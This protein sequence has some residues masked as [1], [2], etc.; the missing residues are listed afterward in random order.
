MNMTSTGILFLV[1]TVIYISAGNAKNVFVNVFCK[2]ENVGQFGQQS[3]LEC[4][5][6]TI[7]EAAD[8]KIRVVTWKKQGAKKPLLVFHRAETIQQP[9]YEFAEPSWNDKNM[10]VS[11]LINKTL[12]SDAG[13]YMCTVMTNSGDGESHANLKVTAKYSVPVIRSIPEKIT[14][15]AGADLMCQSD[16]GYPEGQIHWFEDGKTE[17]IKSSKMEVKQ[18]QSGLFNL[19]SKLTLVQGSNFSKYTCVVFN[20]SGGK[21]TETTFEVENAPEAGGREG[22]KGLDSVSKIVAPLVVIGSLIVGLLLALLF[23]KR[24]TQRDHQEVGRC[25]SDVEEV[26]PQEM[27]EKCQCSLV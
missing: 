16:G 6:Q 10:N 17:R 14:Q 18:T 12:L 19:S 5:V 25:E 21:E 11:L 23:Y 3:L 7:Q 2:A 9:G 1:I 8:A 26:G 13:V 15:K 27:D 22:R 20:A 24:R 4:E